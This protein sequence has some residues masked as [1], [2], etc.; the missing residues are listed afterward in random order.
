MDP[1]SALITGGATLGAAGISYAGQQA[2]N[3]ANIQMAREQMKF[4]ERMSNTSHQREVEDLRAAG[5]NP[6]ISAT[7]GASTPAGASATVGNAGDAFAKHI[8]PMVLLS[9]EKMMAD[10][11]KTKAETGVQNATRSNLEEQNKNLQA[12]NALLQANAAK[13]L[14][15]MGLTDAQIRK[16]LIEGDALQY[17]LGGKQRAGIYNDDGQVVKTVKGLIRT[18][19]DG[20]LTYRDDYYQMTPLPEGYKWR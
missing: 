12:Q 1:V 2:A 6:L 7:G 5:L 3:A 20:D 4:Q 16:S 11:S 15:D 8:D 13:V 19:R 17:E 14:K 9:A 10:V 18:L